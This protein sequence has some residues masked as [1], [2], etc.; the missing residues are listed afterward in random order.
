MSFSP[1]EIINVEQLK[2]TREG[3]KTHIYHD[4]D[5]SKKDNE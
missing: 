5:E 1:R 3:Q 2:D 4:L